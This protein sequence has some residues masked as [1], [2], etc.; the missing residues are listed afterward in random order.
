MIAFLEKQ[1]LLVS[2]TPLQRFK[3]S[4]KL[5]NNIAAI[6][7]DFGRYILF[8]L[9]F[10]ISRL[11]LSTSSFQSSDILVISEKKTMKLN[12]HNSEELFSK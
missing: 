11:S 1:I 7:S 6:F 3:N 2:S 8:I 4:F 5:I 12:Q 9:K 10:L